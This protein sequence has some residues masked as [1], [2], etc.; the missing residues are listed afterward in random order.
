MHMHTHMHV[1][2]RTHVRTRTHTCTDLPMPNRL[3]SARTDLFTLAV[4]VRAGRDDLKG[5]AEGAWNK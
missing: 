2:A 4:I 5:F 1:N 3:G